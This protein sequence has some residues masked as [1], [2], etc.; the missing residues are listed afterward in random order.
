[1]AGPSGERSPG[2]RGMFE[3]FVHSEV[4]GSL[5]LLTCTIVALALA[6]SPWSGVYDRILHT[7]IG[8]SL[9]DRS[10]ALSVH[11]FVNDF[12]MAVF[13]FVVGLEI[14]RELVVGQLS[15]IRKAVLPV[16]A[17]IGGMAVPAALYAVFNAGGEAAGGWGI[18]M[19]T[20]IAF[21]LGVLALFGR[22]MP[23][24][25]KVFLTALAIADDLGA[26]LVIA[27]F[28]TPEIRWTSLAAA[29][30]LLAVTRL[31]SRAGIRS[32]GVYAVLVLGVWAA[33]FASGI[34]A[35]VAGVLVAFL[36]P[37]RARRDP[38]HFLETAGSRLEGL[39]GTALSRESMVG[40]RS[41]LDALTDLR[42]AADD[43]IP[44]GIAFERELHPVVAFLILPLFAL[45]NAGVVVDAASFR[46]GL[47]HPL[48]LGIVAGLV[49]GKQIGITLFSWLAVRS[50]R[51]AL[52]EGVRWGQLYGAACL[53]GI[54]FTMSLFITG[55]AFPDEALIVRAKVGILLASLL[56]AVWGAA[57]LAVG[58]AGAGTRTSSG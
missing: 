14:K 42:Q 52:P 58:R 51:A 19:A 29:V 36:V 23:I 1:M 17:A 15:S 32:Q 48:G 37:V 4:S 43:M 33:V 34:H 35:T 2:L 46:E 11:H 55:L 10:F 26:V 28:Y 22:R 44:P 56:A 3:H 8:V 25:L 5:V 12:L 18:P 45:C 7:K 41:Q 49:L 16:T 40:D 54:G 47:S 38:K 50:G 31:A 30:V 27:V 24:G 21:A 53:A 13:F 57:V 39:R 9:G 20:D 6:N